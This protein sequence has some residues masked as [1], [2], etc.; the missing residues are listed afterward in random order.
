MDTKRILIILVVVLALIG[1]ILSQFFEL[2]NVPDHNWESEYH[3]EKKEPK[4]LYAL[5]RLLQERYGKNS[6]KAID[7]ETLL[8]TIDTNKLF[9]LYGDNINFS[10]TNRTNLLEFINAGNDALLIARNLDLSLEYEPKRHDPIDSL[11]TVTPPDEYDSSEDDSPEYD[12]SEDDSAEYDSTDYESDDNEDDYYEDDS[13][14]HETSEDDTYDYEEQEVYKARHNIKYLTISNFDSMFHFSFEPFDSLEHNYSYKN[15][16]RDLDQG[17]RKRFKSIS[18]S[19]SIDLKP[20]AYTSDYSPFYVRK[21]FG[22]GYL[23]VHTVPDLFT[24]LGTKQSYYLDHFNHVFK[25]MDADGIIT[26]K[27]DPFDSYKDTNKNPKPP[28]KNPLEFILNTPS[29][30]WAYY[31]LVATLLLFVIFRG[32][33][34]QK[35]IPTVAENK[36]TSLEYVQTLSTLYQNQKQNNKL[37]NH[38]R[39]GFHHRIKSKYYIDPKDEF[40]VSKLAAKSKVDPSEITGLMHKLNSAKGA[41]FSDDQ[42]IILYKQIESFY[43]KAK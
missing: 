32:K 37:V 42:L 24:N 9:I 41:D 16:N 43:Q 10:E 18:Q 34:T 23:Y 13:A 33:R 17:V 25:W 3:L 30:A 1:L 20:L 14:D 28:S 39:D 36:N 40:Y 29:L 38:M 8:D 31:L 6:I 4:D 5:S 22:D 7:Y 2:R 26:R 27:A 12:S 19:T 11:Y 21:K 15:Y 35:I